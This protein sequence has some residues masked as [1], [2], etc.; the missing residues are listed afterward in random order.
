MSTT[1][2]SPKAVARAAY[3]VAK[4]ALPA[5]S[6]KFSPKRFTQPQL[7]VCLVL[8]VFHKTD[9]RD[10]VAILQ[11]NP[12]LCKA[13]GLA[14]V[15]HFTTLQKASKRLLRLR[16]ANELL[17]HSVK[18]L[19]QSK[20]VALA[21]VDSTGLEAKHISRYFVRRRRSKQ[22]QT[23]E[24]T[25]Y[26]R[27]PK[28]AMVCDWRNHLVLSAITTRG[29]SVDIDQ[30]EKTLTP[31]IDRYTLKHILA[32]AGY[33][34]ESNHRFARDQHNIRSTIPP[35][36]GRPTTKPFRGKYRRLM[37]RG[38]NRDTYGQRWQV[39]TVFS[40]IKRNQGDVL[41]ARAYWS[42]NREMLLKVLTHN[43]GIILLINELFYK[44][45]AVPFRGVGIVRR[46]MARS[47]QTSMPC[48]R[49]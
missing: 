3:A 20:K 18:A 9:Y 48:L 24:N 49:R 5:H 27:W 45:T 29:P 44:A 4:K 38:F 1:S 36:H 15:P 22:L 42:Q 40:M 32:D 16:M 47:A 21:A 13:F 37:Q 8:K 34:S 41:R 7:F 26:R 11:D 10:L 17:H 30:F 25:H 19:R 6:H 43:I 14:R 28:L 46:A 23:Y 39:E 31:A 35:T 12:D 2:K 33:D